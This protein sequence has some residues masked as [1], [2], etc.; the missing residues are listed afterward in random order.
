MSRSQ[1]PHDTIDEI[2]ICPMC[3]TGSVGRVLNSTADIVACLQQFRSKR[4]EYFVCLSLDNKRRLLA[5]RIVTIG[6]LDTTI[7]HPREVFA[8]AVLDRAHSIIVAHNHPSGI[9][10]PSAEDIAATQQ[11]LSAGRLLGISLEDHI[12]VTTNG[13]FSFKEHSMLP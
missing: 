2:V 3:H 1:H 4:Q 8:G 6:L 5:Q 12:I 11:L 13:H 10:A 7:I 9:P